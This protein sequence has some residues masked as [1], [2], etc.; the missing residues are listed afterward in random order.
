MAF[1]TII[2]LY[3]CVIIF[4]D[5]TKGDNQLIIGQI[6]GLRREITNAFL[7]LEIQI[8]RE[9]SEIQRLMDKSPVA[10]EIK[11]GN[12]TLNGDDSDIFST[13]VWNLKQIASRCH[14]R[15]NKIRNKVRNV[16]NV[17]KSK[18]EKKTLISDLEKLES[19]YREVVEDLDIK[20]EVVSN[21]ELK[22]SEIRDQLFYLTHIDTSTMRYLQTRSPWRPNLV[23][24]EHRRLKLRISGCPN[25]IVDCSINDIT[26]LDDDSF[27]VTY[28][29]QT[30]LRR[31]NLDGLLLSEFKF[32]WNLEGVTA[33]NETHVIVG[34][35]G[36]RTL[37][38]LSVPGGFKVTGLILLEE[39]CGSDI[40]QTP[41]GL[42]LVGCRNSS[43]IRVYNPKWQL[44]DVLQQDDGK[45]LGLLTRN[46]SEEAK[47][48]LLPKSPKG[49]SLG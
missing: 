22:L 35:P 49:C 40:D 24:L 31:F 21:S 36:K 9:E 15:V 1:K 39:P 41:A 18:H 45:L 8:R 44:Q 48:R 34:A 6:E 43:T 10:T 29:N 37:I 14:V 42:F 19:D 46:Q 27:V 17:F 12:E 33:I 4:C 20:K 38:I 30:A 13:K 3:I 28:T 47:N 2:G 26:S 5:T 25:W 11:C 32:P 23:K 7:E 16:E